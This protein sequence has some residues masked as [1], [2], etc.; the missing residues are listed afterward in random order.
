MTGLKYHVVARQKQI[1]P[2]TLENTYGMKCVSESQR[3]KQF[4]SSFSH[5]RDC[6]N[7][8][9]GHFRDITRKSCASTLRI[10]GH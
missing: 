5:S 8:D 4:K 1:F 10:K 3:E 2:M 6:D 9:F 7:C